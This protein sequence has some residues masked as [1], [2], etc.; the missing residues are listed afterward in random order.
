MI[1]GP[2]YSL[3]AR[4]HDLWILL[5]WIGI[6][7]AI[8]L[9]TFYTRSCFEFTTVRNP[10]APCQPSTDL[11][12]MFLAAIGGGAALRD[13]R[14]AMLGFLIV[15]V[16]ASVFFVTALVAPS[17]FGLTGAGL[18]DQIIAQAV[19]L[20]IT[21]QFPFAIFLSLVG[22]MLG[23]WVGG[24]INRSLIDRTQQP[25]LATVHQS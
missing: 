23:L 12:L 7:T 20:S 17:L 2:V 21:Y 6:V 8:M 9:N 4:L 22:S 5:A 3:L 19:I 14:I 18:M 11:A 13:E 1:H 10:I 25:V 16:F 24:K 15:H